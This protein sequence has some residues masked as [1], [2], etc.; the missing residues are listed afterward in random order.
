MK[1]LIKLLFLGFVFSSASFAADKTSSTSQEAA[2]TEADQRAYD[3]FQKAGSTKISKFSFNPYENVISGVAA[4]VIGNVG[5][6]TTE[7]VTLKVTYSAIQTIGII[8]I[9]Q[10]IYQS[11]SP[12]IDSSLQNLLSDEKEKSYTKERLAG[13]LLKIFAEEDR[14]KRLSIFYSSSFLTL[15][16][17]MNATIYKSTGQLKK[18]YL[19]L[20]GVNAIVAIYSAV[21]KSRYEE[22]YYGGSVDISPVAKIDSKEKPIYG[23]MLGV[24]F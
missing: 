14:A 17:A 6:L 5:Y 19:F 18:T 11:K 10:G 7:S 24:R 22:A 15:Q 1:L 8:N 9:G 20:G 4:F 21:K 13:R 3:F 16:Y 2:T 23:L 12:T